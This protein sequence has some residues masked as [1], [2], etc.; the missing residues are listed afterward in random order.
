MCNDPTDLAVV[1]KLVLRR[2]KLVDLLVGRA[3]HL[4]VR[5]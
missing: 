4:A 2:Q 1:L 3:G 5:I